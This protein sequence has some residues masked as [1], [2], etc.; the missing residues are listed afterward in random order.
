MQARNLFV[1]IPTCP[2]Y[3]DHN[4]NGSGSFVQLDCRSNITSA[5]SQNF[6]CLAAHT[7][8]LAAGVAVGG[9]DCGKLTN[10]SFTLPWYCSMTSLTSFRVFAQCSQLRLAYS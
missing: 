9:T 4:A 3:I 2:A 5:N 7:P 10:T 8:A 1:S 6:P